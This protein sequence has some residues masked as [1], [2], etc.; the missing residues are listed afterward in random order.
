MTYATASIAEH[1]LLFVGKD[2]AKTDLASAL[3]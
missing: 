1:P 3:D 2:F